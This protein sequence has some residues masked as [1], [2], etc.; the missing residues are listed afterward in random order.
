L[1]L[2]GLSSQ[3]PAEITPAEAAASV[4]LV[5]AINA[6]DYVTA[7]G[8]LH[9][10]GLA[11]S[12]LESMAGRLGQT[13]QPV[14][15]GDPFLKGY[16]FMAELGHG[17]KVWARV[18]KAHAI[19]Y[20]TPLWTA[21]MLN[22]ETWAVRC[23]RELGR[24]PVPPIGVL[25]P[26]FPQEVIRHF[27]WYDRYAEH[28]HSVGLNW[29]RLNNFD[30]DDHAEAYRLLNALYQLIK[31]RKPDAFVWLLVEPTV[32]KS[33]VRWLQTM[34]L[35]YDGLMVGNL[36]LL[37][38]GRDRDPDTGLYNFRN[39]YYSPNW[40]RF[41][42][43]DPIRQKGGLNFYNF[44]L[45]NVANR[46]DP[47]GEVIARATAAPTPDSCDRQQREDIEAAM[48]EACAKIY[49]YCVTPNDPCA[50]VIADGAKGCKKQPKVECAKPGD[51]ECEE[52]V[53]AYTLGDVITLC[54]T[55]AWPTSGV[56]CLGHG[57]PMT[58]NCILVHELH[59]VG[60]KGKNLDDANR[61]QKCLGCPYGEPH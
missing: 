47:Y 4:Q 59:H 45:N 27:Q 56:N 11:E 21:E 16:L 6:G 25:N 29:Y 9:G 1:L 43:V 22:P 12:T 54:P 48:K 46:T 3:L 15:L 31:A 55:Q 23:D 33:D 24:S 41:V 37:F 19:N 40:G 30:A 34:Q 60:A 8:I 52:D 7:L 61:L 28:L 18:M 2:F 36:S 32:D 44:V 14:G 5:A 58:L 10:Q 13:P 35:G 20:P 17:K 51:P 49:N 42:Q 50:N 53:C 26:A 39:R 57:G 38:Q